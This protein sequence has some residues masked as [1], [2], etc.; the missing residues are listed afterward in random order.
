MKDKTLGE[1]FVSWEDAV[2]WLKLQPDKQDIVKACFYD[3]PLKESLDRYYY[4]S[5][6]FDI[7]QLLQRVKVGKAL[8][9]GAGRGISSYALAKDGWDVYALEPDKSEI[10]GSGVIK[11]I[12]SE[13]DLPINVVE[14]IGES[15]PFED[16]SFDLV[17]ARQ[18]LHHANDLDKMCLEIARV[19]KPQ[20]IFIA[21]REHVINKKSDLGKF[22]K[23]HPLN[24][25][26]GGEN[27]FLLKEYISAIEKSGIKIEKIL[28][29]YSSNINLYPLTRKT[30]K[31]KIINIVKVPLPNFLVDF[32]IKLYEKYTNNPGRIY[33]FIG[34]K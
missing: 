16:N 5:E 19:L 15:L 11:K 30:F 12:A 14:T 31:Q 7:Q 18:V 13:Y 3:D 33:S 32:M 9:I 34:Y 27:A 22:L 23:K 26:Y 24:H 20:G 2:V 10:V 28:K 21:T 1:K 25:L 29:P 6:W 4:S 17:Y 8:D